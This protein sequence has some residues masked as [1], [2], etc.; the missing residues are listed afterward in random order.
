MPFSLSRRSLLLSA[1]VSTLLP[2]PALVAGPEPLDPLLD[3]RCKVHPIQKGE[4]WQA[5]WIWHPGQLTAHLHAA[6]VQRALAR[7][8]D[9]GYPGRYRQPE[10]YAYFRKRAT[11][12]A[13]TRIRWEGPG[14]RISMFVNGE[15]VDV[16]RR[17]AVLAAGEVELRC[18]MDFTGSLPCLIVEGAGVATGG[19]WETSLDRKQ[20]VSAECD[21][22]FNCPHV[23]PDRKP[24]LTVTIPPRNTP[25][26]F[27]V[28]AGKS[29]LID[30]GHD[31]LGQLVFE[32]AGAGELSVTV[33]ESALEAR[34]TNPVHFEQRALPVTELSAGKRVIS[35]PERCVR[36]AQFSSTGP[37][38]VSALR[39]EARVSPVEYKGSF[40]SSDP[41]LNDLWAAGA[42]TLHTNLHDF[43]LDGIKRDGL[44]WWDGL[45]AMEAGDAV[46]LDAAA[47]RHTIVSL[48][49]PP[50]PDASDLAIIDTPL[51]VLP[52][53]E[54]D[55]LVRGDLAFSARY[56][57]RVEDILAL[58]ASF[59]NSDGF[60]DARQVQTYGFYP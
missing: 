41:E 33:G 12:P 35:L 31:E 54:N 46:F 7:C 10:N 15:A 22:E 43:Y 28:P 60:V 21:P 45:L 9:V 11:L 53:L 51:Y 50:H 5:L 57:D 59:Q 26:S 48:T 34:N 27:S 20:W 58:F 17:S 30:F 4:A 1:P 38:A 24:E 55:Y 2:A 49:L 19:G 40:E 36:F 52:A 18:E 13:E 47:A 25:S 6:M 3:Q 14:G 32:A 42:A 37:A 23:L 8:T 56:R 16:T 39:L 44:C 29:V